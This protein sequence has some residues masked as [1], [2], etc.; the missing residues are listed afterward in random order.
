MQRKIRFAGS[1]GQYCLFAVVFILSFSLCLFAFAIE[2][3]SFLPQRTEVIEKGQRTVTATEAITISRYRSELTQKQIMGFYEQE[4]AKRGWKKFQPPAGDEKRYK[5]MLVYVKDG[6]NTFTVVIAPPLTK[7]KI[8][9]NVMIAEP[10]KIVVLQEVFK[11]PRQLDFMPVPAAVTEFVYNT[12]YPSMIGLGYLTHNSVDAV[13]NFYLLNMSKF[14][15]SLIGQTP[16]EG[17]Y[18]LSQWIKIVDP[19]TKAVPNLEAIGFVDLV[20]PLAVRGKTLSFA[21]GKKSCTITIY[22][23][24]DIVEKAVGTRFDMGFMAEHGR[25]LICVYYFYDEKK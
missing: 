15:W 6:I 25:T 12:Y 23:F 1:V 17:M 4:L 9:Y 3:E 20:P 13:S 5:D 18:N 24:D 8:S 21:Q 22:R 19:F 14:G 7:G 11:P 10:T 2:L 16:Q